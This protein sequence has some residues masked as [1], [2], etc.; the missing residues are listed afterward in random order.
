MVISIIGVLASVVLVSLNSARAKARD[1]R[2]ITDL[3][4]VQTALELYYDANGQ[5][6]LPAGGSGVWSGHCPSY[7]NYDNYISGLA[8]NYMASLPVDPKY[9]I[10]GNCYLYLSNST[11]YALITHFTMET[12]CG[13]DPSA[14]CNPP[15][16]RS[17]DRQ[18]CVQPT[19]G[20]F[21]SGGVAW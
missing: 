14:A 20:V 3:K 12:I 11:D 7:G 15:H 6:P 5:Y 1:A 4:Q 9:D 21:S 19:I 8:P 13:G 18:C 2:R 10:G 17:I 16:I